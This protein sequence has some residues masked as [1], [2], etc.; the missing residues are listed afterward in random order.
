MHDALKENKLPESCWVSSFE[1]PQRTH[2]MKKWIKT[3]DGIT[4]FYVYMTE[5]KQVPEKCK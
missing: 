5:N 2:S 1:Y 3:F 4:I